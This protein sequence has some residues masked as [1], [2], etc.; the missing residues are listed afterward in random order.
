LALLTGGLALLAP[1]GAGIWSFLAPLFRKS[2]SAQL[3][4]AL[5]DQVPDDGRPYCFPVVT[6]R[7]DAWTKYQQQKVGAV[8]LTRQPGAEKPVAFTAKCPHAGCSI[9]YSREENKFQCPC[10]TSAF[11]LD[12]TRVNGD[13]EVAPRDMDTLEVALQAIPV[14][15][16]TP[17]TEVL[18]TWVDF[19]TGHREKIASE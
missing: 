11:H 18:V 3:R 14:A 5:L 13:A 7:Q 9:G 15:G 19:Q 1:L 16:G 12:G 10:H 8:Y 17:V 2:R 6:D 4:V